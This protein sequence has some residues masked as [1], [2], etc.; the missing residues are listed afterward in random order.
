MA[1]GHISSKLYGL[2]NVA[3][4]R[5]GSPAE[6]YYSTDP[7]LPPVDLTPITSNPQGG[8]ELLSAGEEVALARII[9][10]DNTPIPE[11]Y[12]KYLMIEVNGLAAEISFD[13]VSRFTARKV[14][15][16][17]AL[18]DQ[19]RV[20]FQD[21]LSRTSFVR[22]LAPAPDDLTAFEELAAAAAAS[23]ALTPQQL[24][25]LRR[26]DFNLKIISSTNADNEINGYTLLLEAG[27]YNEVV[28]EYRDGVVI[29]GGQNDPAGPLARG[30]IIYLQR[31]LRANGYLS[32][33]KEN[34]GVFTLSTLLALQSYMSNKELMAGL[35]VEVGSQL[36]LQ[37]NKEVEQAVARYQAVT[38]SSRTDRYRRYQLA[39]EALNKLSAAVNLARRYS[40]I[41]SDRLTAAE[42]R[43][44]EDC[45]KAVLAHKARIRVLFADIF[46]QDVPAEALY[47]L[48]NDTIRTQR[49][50]AGYLAAYNLRDFSQDRLGT[51]WS[52]LVK[53]GY[54]D[55]EGLL[56]PK[57]TKIL[58]NPIYG[59][60]QFQVN[61]GLTGAEKAKLFGILNGCRPGDSAKQLES[62]KRFIDTE[63]GLI[64]QLKSWQALAGDDP[65]L[66]KQLKD[67]IE[68][69]ES[70]I[71]AAYI[72]G[73][74][75]EQLHIEEQL[76]LIDQQ[77]T[78]EIEGSSG[79]GYVSKLDLSKLTAQPGAAP[80]TDQ[81]IWDNLL[82]SGYIDERG[83][84]MD[85]FNA[86][87]SEAEFIVAP[88]LSG[89]KGQI[90]QLLGS[91]SPKPAQI[92]YR[93]H[94]A[95]KISTRLGSGPERGLII[96]FLRGTLQEKKIT[97]VGKMFGDFQRLINQGLA[98]ELEA[99]ARYYQNDNIL[100]S[101]G[102][103]AGEMSDNTVN[104]NDAITGAFEELGIYGQ[105]Y[106]GELLNLAI[107]LYS[108]MEQHNA[109]A[110]SPAGRAAGAV[111][112]QFRTIMTLANA[113]LQLVAGQ[114]EANRT[115]I[116]KI[117]AN[118]SDDPQSAKIEFAQQLDAELDKF[119]LIGTRGLKGGNQLVI[120][121]RVIHEL[122]SDFARNRVLQGAISYEQL[123]Q[124]GGRNEW[125]K[126]NLPA[127]AAAGQFFIVSPLGI[128]RIPECQLDYVE[129]LPANAYESLAEEVERDPIKFVKNER[130]ASLKLAVAQFVPVSDQ[131]LLMLSSIPTARLNALDLEGIITVFGEGDK[132]IFRP[133]SLSLLPLEASAFRRA[134]DVL[135]GRRQG[136][137]DPFATILRKLAGGVTRL[138][139]DEKNTLF[140]NLTDK[141][142]AEYVKTFTT[143]D[144]VE[145]QALATGLLQL[146]RA[147]F[148]L[149]HKDGI[150]ETKKAA[151]RKL[152]G[153]LAMGDLSITD[154]RLTS[155]EAPA[156]LVR[157]LEEA[158]RGRVTLDVAD[159]KKAY[160]EA[161]PVLR[162]I[163]DGLFTLATKYPPEEKGWN[164]VWGFITHHY[165][166]LIKVM[167]ETVNSPTAG[168]YLM[169][170][171]PNDRVIEINVMLYPDKVD[172]LNGINARI[173]DLELQL[174]TNSLPAN[175]P[176]AVEV[177]ACQHWTAEISVLTTRLKNLRTELLNSSN[178]QD[179][180]LREY[181]NSF[182]QL[183]EQLDSLNSNPVGYLANADQ[184]IQMISVLKVKISRGLALAA[185]K[186]GKPEPDKK[187]A[188][189]LVRNRDIL[190][191]I[192]RA[193]NPVD[194]S[195][196]PSAASI[197]LRLRTLITDRNRLL[198]LY[199]E[200]MELE[201][202]RQEIVDFLS[203]DR[204]DKKKF[205][206]LAALF[207]GLLG[208][209][210]PQGMAVATVKWLTGIFNGDQGMVLGPDGVSTKQ[211]IGQYLT[212]FFREHEN[213]AL[214]LS[215]LVAVPGEDH[216]VT[217]AKI[218]LSKF[219]E[220][221]PSDQ[222]LSLAK[223]VPAVIGMTPGMGAIFSVGSQTL[224]GIGEAGYGATRPSDLLK[225]NYPAYQ[226][227]NSLL[228]F[229]A[230]ASSTRPPMNLSSQ[231]YM[232]LA[233]TAKGQEFMATVIAG[234]TNDRF[235][236]DHLDRA[237]VVAFYD[238]F[239]QEVLPHLNNPRLQQRIA[240]L[241]AA[242][243]LPLSLAELT[244][245]GNAGGLELLLATLP[246]GNGPS[247]EFKLYD[248][249]STHDSTLKLAQFVESV[250]KV[251]GEFN[252][253]APVEDIA[254]YAMTSF[255]PLLTLQ[256]LNPRFQDRGV[257]PLTEI[258]T[259]HYDLSATESSLDN[260]PIFGG[261]A[262][263]SL[264]DANDW[265]DLY[266]DKT[267]AGLQEEWAAGGASFA[268]D[269]AKAGGG[270]AVN[271]VG[272]MGRQINMGFQD[273]FGGLGDLIS[274]CQAG[275]KGKAIEALMR[276]SDGLAT[277]TG[278]FVVF[279]A[280]GVI[281][282]SD[283][284]AEIEQGNFAAAA[285]KAIAVAALTY[286][287]A[288][289][290]INVL[291]ALFIKSPGLLISR[292]QMAGGRIRLA[293]TK[294]EMLEAAKL[295]EA[296]MARYERETSW[297]R[298]SFRGN[299]G[300]K[301]AYYH[302]N[303]FALG[304][305]IADGF[306]SA[307][308]YMSGGLQ[309]Q[310]SQAGVQ[311][312]QAETAT[313][314]S[315]KFYTV[316]NFIDG[317][318]RYRISDTFRN[319]R[320]AFGLTRN[321]TDWLANKGGQFIGEAAAIEANLQA[322]AEQPGTLLTTNYSKALQTLTFSEALYTE[323]AQAK[324]EN[325]FDRFHQ[326]VQ[327]DQV[328]RHKFLGSR[329]MESYQLFKAFSPEA[330]T[331]GADGTKVLQYGSFQGEL[332]FTG[333][334]YL[335][336]VEAAA[337]KNFREFRSILRLH[338]RTTG[339][340]LAGASV[341]QI[342]S[343][344]EKPA[345]TYSEMGGQAYFAAITPQGKPFNPVQFLSDLTVGKGLDAKIPIT[346]LV[347]EP[348]TGETKPV[349]REV[350]GKQILQILYRQQVSAQRGKAPQIV[351]SQEIDAQVAQIFNR[352]V[353]QN[354]RFKMVKMAGKRYQYGVEGR[355]RR[356]GSWTAAQ[357]KAAGRRL[358]ELVGEL[359]SAP[360]AIGEYETRIA[361][362]G[363]Q[364]RP[365]TF[366]GVSEALRTEFYE[367]VNNLP[368]GKRITN[369][370]FAENVRF[371][372]AGEDAL[373][374]LITKVKGEN[375]PVESKLVV[376]NVDG[377]PTIAIKEPLAQRLL[378]YL[379]SNG[380]PLFEELF[381]PTTRPL[382]TN[383][384]ALVA[385]AGEYVA[386][387][388]GVTV[389]GAT[390]E[391]VANELNW[392]K[393]STAEEVAAKYQVDAAKANALKVAAIT[394]TELP[395]VTGCDLSLDP[396]TGTI[397]VKS[398]SETRTFATLEEAKLYALELAHTNAVRVE[399]FDLLRYEAYGETM[400]NRALAAGGMALSGALA[401]GFIKLLF[402]G[403]DAYRN[404]IGAFDSLEVLKSAG[405][406][407]IG[408]GLMGAKMQ[409][410]QL[411]G[412]NRAGVLG[413]A[414]F[415]PLMEGTNDPNRS[416]DQRLSQEVGGLVGLGVFMG[417]ERITA[418]ALTGSFR[419]TTSSWPK[420]T[421]GALVG[422]LAAT[423]ATIGTNYLLS[424]DWFQSH[425]SWDTRRVIADGLGRAGQ[426]YSSYVT[427]QML[428]ALVSLGTRTL[429]KIEAGPA[430]WF[431]AIASVGVNALTNIGY[432]I[433]GTT[434]YDIEAYHLTDAWL[435]QQRSN[436]S[437]ASLSG[438]GNHAANGVH[439]VASQLGDEY[440]AWSTAKGVWGLSQCMM[441]DGSETCLQ[442]VIDKHN[443]ENWDTLN[444]AYASLLLKHV[445]DVRRNGDQ[446]EFTFDIDAINNEI[447]ANGELRHMLEF[448]GNFH[449]EMFNGHVKYDSARDKYL[450][451]GDPNAYLKA[452][453]GSKIMLNTTNSRG[454]AEQ[455]SFQQVVQ[456]Y[457]DNYFMM[458]GQRYLQIEH[459]K[460]TGRYTIGDAAFQ[461]DRKLG[462]VDAQ[463]NLL[464]PTPAI[465]TGIDKVKT[466]LMTRHAETLLGNRGASFDAPDFYVG[467]ALMQN[468]ADQKKVKLDD[469]A[470][471]L[472]SDKT[473]ARIGLRYA[474]RVAELRVE[475]A[476]KKE[477]LAA[478]EQQ[479][480]MAP[481]A[482]SA[483]ML[484]ICRLLYELETYYVVVGYKGSAIAELAAFRHGFE[485]QLGANDPA[486]VDAVYHEP[487][488]AT[489]AD[490]RQIRGNIGSVD[491]TD[492]L[493]QILAE[494]DNSSTIPEAV[495]LDPYRYGGYHSIF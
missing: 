288:T 485:E 172:D 366:A 168:D 101:Q 348:Q 251:V 417:G 90:Y 209:Q 50:K 332:M 414:I 23:G 407:A 87:R 289:T 175:H 102:R 278:S 261:V 60:D 63:L 75:T 363:V 325:N 488:N 159:F 460:G 310:V 430:G 150:N 490:A 305:R 390:P 441:N 118:A 487:A 126:A 61:A 96:S 292:M 427:G 395:R 160:R 403:V 71:R 98:D 358:A 180:E 482:Y 109:Y 492:P 48:D 146:R 111:P 453:M 16:D 147:L 311:V 476:N 415:M 125:I 51:I 76:Q 174:G 346:T 129:K 438:L 392:I 141:N 412:M 116:L 210:P 408:W 468:L 391:A 243:K 367:A 333:E 446:I 84:I 30:I 451:A 383:G 334:T 284:V 401:E 238:Y 475:L 28:A 326:L 309:V 186:A 239:K 365:G 67:K 8:N 442:F 33:N 317:A 10:G 296:E 86:L 19:L 300:I 423:G 400:P 375:I 359:R 277:T 40:D 107:T 458:L 24:D 398:G 462:L 20:A 321:F 95:D 378:S 81:L 255:D 83:Q 422:A 455:V 35:D 444:Y 295:Y 267:L 177:K 271:F 269:A 231:V 344:F 483:A 247:T 121:P 235:A 283:I 435:E 199:A 240:Q 299:L 459:E 370:T 29:R 336:L 456:E 52:A 110:N 37:K 389:A 331:T 273:T 149:L 461:E 493:D 353:N 164:G 2:G 291:K 183:V 260:I 405:N 467:L 494:G 122:E 62:F 206:R 5:L 232:M 200:K 91:R 1:E 214:S 132:W 161:L 335:K 182:L 197:D 170:G 254:N 187:K 127:G 213:A 385:R 339:Q 113:A 312:G 224:G 201:I 156:D 362:L 270:F 242:N 327:Q 100:S 70:R 134:A 314:E 421:G 58:A 99:M 397:V 119:A 138:T 41:P 68:A 241:E 297:F 152:A 434:K 236:F 135:D 21:R 217:T 340:T 429:T 112:L 208:N 388:T 36:L 55:A 356:A 329:K 308:T 301:L 436:S 416:V 57:F 25:A 472:G 266:A 448:N 218:A 319:A 139:L 452:L 163:H 89:I 11:G 181:I 162:E 402:E 495:D 128:T 176:L 211:S 39:K 157:E 195:G 479:S 256:A 323:L 12:I 307:R 281:F 439:W 202:K 171:L 262:S 54:I 154:A 433:G 245:L 69:L 361:K 437:W 225:F 237:A 59:L 6:L 104:A 302:V 130:A 120:T 315:G 342:Y 228:S 274:A 144:A 105:S 465:Q 381:N 65:A 420:A 303:P 379:G 78:M 17:P 432:S 484:D 198:P 345:K 173:A 372:G 207:D 79:V 34:E 409:F 49:R 191:L 114:S 216:D 287:Q 393:Q 368:E 473:F 223:S 258:S 74:P 92:R 425:V 419:P 140:A 418:R 426:V 369:L 82:S 410:A 93:Y 298:E 399:T 43:F 330:F 222:V 253:T 94:Q 352:M 117:V 158:T 220:K 106:R 350:T 474:A 80:N 64:A 31:L 131:E 290:T 4:L 349:T 470:A 431:A 234:A 179:K 450:L 264:L 275:N 203:S 413:Y 355:A 337:T 115:E 464:P 440:V 3:Q 374:S 44:V 276:L 471:T 272:L 212:A 320:T 387:V 169:S 219:F 215:S 306:R 123:V 304:S 282:I 42:K 384:R 286:H 279:E 280:M 26:G 424:T 328:L 354:D 347:T 486:A 9:L 324:A 192:N 252:Q 244:A 396:L 142:I 66:Y 188:E 377:T 190:D 265:L 14:L 443:R 449:Y 103:S 38:G 46:N 386:G 480:L 7:T 221:L 489:E 248:S 341:Q 477:D 382:G 257:D 27:N 124:L 45:Q 338:L 88:E 230:N 357:L 155:D 268:W 246:G 194:G 380:A 263:R 250:L 133:G 249:F 371:A 318:R 13:H 294:T 178:D 373:R 491:Y 166:K 481:A 404:G 165:N 167:T 351:V 143:L 145:K 56:Q 32:V 285:G 227:Y 22:S 77:L 478:M 204:F 189:K 469:W 411:L 360:P 406:G 73:Y 466:A 322:A 196:Q 229:G 193:L 15:G 148:Q 376:V 316:A 136:A 151:L 85:K 53:A 72:P 364:A 137:T 205:D 259:V 457:K 108:L 394:A 445:K 18:Q 97:N 226:F 313:G 343:A 428:A 447:N 153:Y 293:L 184:I 185:E 463:G 233:G 47:E 454:Q